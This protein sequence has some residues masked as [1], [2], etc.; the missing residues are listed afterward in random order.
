LLRAASEPPELRGQQL[1]GLPQRWTTHR[2]RMERV[3]RDANCLY[4][5]GDPLGLA[6]LLRDL[7]QIESHVTRVASSGGPPTGGD[8]EILLEERFASVDP[9]KWIVLGEP[10]VV[11]G[12]LET[13]APGG[14]EHYSGIAT[15]QAF[16]LDDD[17]PLLLEFEL[18]PLT[19]GFDSQLVAAATETGAVSY[20][21]SFYA[22]KTQFGIY[23]QTTE[24]I[25]G[26]WENLEPGW[27]PRAFGPP[28]EVNVTY[29]VMAEITKRTWRV[30]V[31]PRDVQPLQPPLWDT[32]TV[33]MDEL[34]QTHIL[35]AD[36]EPAESTA[37]TRWGPITI[38][39]AR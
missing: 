11:E 37:A 10:R 2:E 26:P 27:K 15:R 29:R 4:T 31:W 14:W 19:L 38:S 33:P 28:I 22:P 18:T 16:D 25:A 36:V 35:F 30:T 9:A 13:Q 32:G 24:P 7:S 12:H 39:R 3:L 8:R 23:T 17:R 34:A 1:A 20:R 6:A 5:R 21:F